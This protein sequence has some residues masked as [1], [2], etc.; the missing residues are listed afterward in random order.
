[1]NE[2]RVQFCRAVEWSEG[3]ELSGRADG[4]HYDHM[5]SLAW[6]MTRD[7]SLWDAAL[8]ENEAIR[9][10]ICTQTVKLTSDQCAVNIDFVRNRSRNTDYVI[11]ILKVGLAAS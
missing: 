9:L 3:A 5:Q 1:M 10:G 11:H 7:E 4:L 6:A 8:W 2:R